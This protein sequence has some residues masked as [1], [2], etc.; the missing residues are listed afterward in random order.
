MKWLKNALAPG[1]A[2]YGVLAYL[3][4]NYRK[5][6]SRIDKAHTWMP[7]I[8]EMPEYSGYLGLALVK[9]GDKQRAKVFLEKSLSNF[10]H[11][12]FIDKDEKEI[13]QKLIREIQHV[14]QSIST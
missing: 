12:S 11:L 10:E 6:V 7:Q 5:T 1:L 8:I 4:G 2:S 13:K 14:L 9:I 3:K